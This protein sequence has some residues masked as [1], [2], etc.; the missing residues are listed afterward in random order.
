MDRILNPVL[1][2]PPADPAVSLA[3]LKQWAR[4][5][6]DDEDSELSAMLNAAIG[7]LD[8][9]TGI[10]GRCLVMQTWRVAMAAWP[11]CREVRLPF[12]DVSAATVTYYDADGVLQTV[13][14]A[15]YELLADARGSFV[16]FR[17]VFDAPPVE[18]DRSDAVR[19]AAT[20]GYGAPG[21]VPWPIKTAIKMLATNW[22]NN[23]GAIVI[24]AAPAEIPLGVST[25]TA[26]YRYVGV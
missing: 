24:G 6:H 11:T 18:D 23:R 2:T 3:E 16:R 26:P 17:T 9:W 19:I 22:Y 4:V 13:D 7:I 8:G 5:D 21:D 20:A 14:S 1:I 25:L 12:P 15:D 10:L